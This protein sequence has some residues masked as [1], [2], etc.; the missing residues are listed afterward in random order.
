MPNT[1]YPGCFVYIRVKIAKNG[2]KYQIAIDTSIVAYVTDSV[3][4]YVW[5]CPG[6]GGHPVACQQRPPVRLCAGI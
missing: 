6:A 1:N 3:T 4:P 2:N 5:F